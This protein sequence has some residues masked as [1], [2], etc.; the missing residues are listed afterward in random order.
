MFKT[1]EQEQKRRAAERASA[2]PPAPPP[3]QRTV[4]P[5][6]ATAAQ[7]A[8]FAAFE[9]SWQEFEA[10]PEQTGLAM[11]A[12][13]WPPE[14]VPVSGVRRSDSDAARKQRLKRAMLRWH[15][16]KFMAAHERRIAPEEVAAV[17]ERV[18][19]LLQRVQQERVAYSGGGGGPG[20]P[21]PHEAARPPPPG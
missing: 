4:P 14:N 21:P 5:P 9:H 18:N 16:D 1:F 11:A 10:S 20:G 7:I 3:P 15:P 12:L 13:P 6:L 2:P 19:I 8:L 17:L